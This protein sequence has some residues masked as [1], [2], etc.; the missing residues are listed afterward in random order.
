MN[1]P[2]H[3]H[4]AERL[5][6]LANYHGDGNP[7]T[8]AALTAEAQAHATLALVAAVAMQA[9]VDGAEPGMS[10]PEYREWYRVAGVKLGEAG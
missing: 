8:G 2:E 4:E 10:S 6:A 1:G 5:L 9:P 3:Y 7:A